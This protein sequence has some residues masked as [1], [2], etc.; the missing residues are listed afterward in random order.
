MGA[1]VTCFQSDQEYKDTILHD[2]IA[3]YSD[4]HEL[5]RGGFGLVLR[6]NH[7]PAA[8]TL[9]KLFAIKLI[10][11]KPSNKKDHIPEVKSLSKIEPHDNIVQY[12]G[13]WIEESSESKTLPIIT[14]RMIFISCIYFCISS[15]L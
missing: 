2:K 13:F 3:E 4:L 9:P 15:P 8:T 14:K 10:S 1:I 12:C 7:K 6:G 11:F 5:G